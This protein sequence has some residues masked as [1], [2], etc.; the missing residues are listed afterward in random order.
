MRSNTQSLCSSCLRTVPATKHTKGKD[1]FIEKTC[2][3]HGHFVGQVAKD[4]KRFFDKTFD[5][6]GKKFDPL[7]SFHGSC[8]EDCG[9]CDKHRQHV[10]TGLIEITEDCNLSC[11]VCYFG[12]QSSRHL[13]VAEFRDR[14]DTLMK[15]E[16]G[17]LEV[18]QLSGGECLIHP[19]FCQILDEALR[20]NTGRILINTNGLS[21][22]TNERVFNKIKDNKDRVE[23]Y[24]QYDGTDDDVYQR[25][26]GCSLG[27][28]KEEIVTKLNENEIKICLAVTVY[29]D[30]LKDIPAILRLAAQTRHISGITFQRLTKVGTAKGTQIPSV[31]QEDILLAIE[32]SGLMGYKDMVPLPCSHENCTSLGFLF[33]MGD[34]T[35]SLGEYVDYTKC[36]DKLSNRIAFDKTIL[37]YIEKNICDCFV[38]KIFGSTFL[39][40]KLREFA[41][42]NGSCYKDMKIVRILVKNFM[43][44]DTFDFE[45]VQKCCTGVSAGNGKVVPFCI[46]NA[47]KGKHQW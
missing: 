16:S 6:P 29:K 39:L 30:N 23:V 41:T 15:V 37:D 43:D 13:A 3:E 20:A 34:K 18:L 1:V 11:P 5:V 35:Y 46:Y 10:C 8:G 27:K 40:D 14:L 32:D 2:P 47:L 45:R 25:L 31:L 19:D 9:W 44:T 7:C 22:L 33:C 24:L 17:Y 26:R 28:L 21:L 12:K 42:G 38:G 4:A 36:T